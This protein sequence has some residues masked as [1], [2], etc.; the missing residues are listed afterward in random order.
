MAE[1]VQAMGLRYATVTG[2]ARDDLPDGGADHFYRCILAVRE[3]IGRLGRGLGVPAPAWETDREYL[4]RFEEAG[5]D[6]GPAS[7]GA[8]ART[9]A[10]RS[11]SRCTTAT[12]P[13]GSRG[14][15][16]ASCP[17]PTA[18]SR[19]RSSPRKSS[20]TLRVGSYAV[21]SDVS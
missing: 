19:G 14:T 4:L 8:A 15:A 18:R 11:S 10:C 16:R 7:R 3:R 20:A 1:S 6:P 9:R 21:S 12:R 17:A 5:V 2:V 13:E